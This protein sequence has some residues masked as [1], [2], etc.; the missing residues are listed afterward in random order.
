[1]FYWELGA[2]VNKEYGN[3]KSSDLGS[4]RMKKGKKL[5]DSYA[6]LVKKLRELGLC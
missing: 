2:R 1:M 5:N 4:E 6:S 3:P